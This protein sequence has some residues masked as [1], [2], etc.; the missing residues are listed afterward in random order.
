MTR[1]KK[2]AGA[3]GAIALGM[4]IFSYIFYSFWQALAVNITKDLKNKYIKALMMQE[5]AYFEQNKVE[6]MPAHITEVFDTL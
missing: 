2:I 1:M 3:V 6:E 4:A 5:I